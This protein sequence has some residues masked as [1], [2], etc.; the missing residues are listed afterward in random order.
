VR[1]G[2]FEAVVEDL[3]GR[4]VY[5]GGPY[6]REALAALRRMARRFSP[7]AFVRL[8]DAMRARAPRWD[9][10]D[11]LRSLTLLVWGRHDQFSSVERPSAILTRVS[12]ARLIVLEDCGHLPTLEQ[13]EACTQAAREWLKRVS[14]RR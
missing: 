3:V 4:A 7:E 1:A 13:P 9:A 6:A 5:A 10:L 11:V 14:A 2:G 8:N 12:S